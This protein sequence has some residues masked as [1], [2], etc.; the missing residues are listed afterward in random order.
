E[1]RFALGRRRTTVNLA[2]GND[3]PTVRF[4][5]LTRGTTLG[6]STVFPIL[7]YQTDFQYVY[8]L[9]RLLTPTNALR[10]GADMRRQQ[11]NDRADQSSARILDLHPGPGLQSHP[12]FPPR[13]RSDLQRSWGPN[14]LG[15]RSGEL[16]YYIQDDWKAR[17]NLTLNVGARFEHVLRL[18]EVNDLL[19]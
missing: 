17:R 4:S 15:N 1:F 7:R 8:N 6:S 19:D 2:D 9:S 16:N 12:D 13:F 10:V 5:D 3:T 18:S 11:L 14:Y